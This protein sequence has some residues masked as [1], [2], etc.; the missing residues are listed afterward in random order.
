MKEI[1]ATDLHNQWMQNDP[2]YRIEFTALEEEFA[3]ASILIE[4]VAQD[5]Q[6][7]VDN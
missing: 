6:F 5:P 3:L 2:A 1:R 4:T 7:A